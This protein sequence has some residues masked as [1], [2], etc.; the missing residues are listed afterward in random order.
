M[1]ASRILSWVLTQSQALF[2]DSWGDSGF[3]QVSLCTLCSINLKS[4]EQ[5]ANK[6]SL[7][8]IMESLQI[9]KPNNHVC[10]ITCIFYGMQRARDICTTCIY[11]CIYDTGIV[12]SESLPPPPPHPTHTHTR[13]IRLVCCITKFQRIKVLQNYRQ[14][15]SSAVY[16]ILKSLTDFF[17]RDW[18]DQ[19]IKQSYCFAYENRRS[20]YSFQRD[21]INHR[22]RIDWSTL[23]CPVVELWN[24]LWGLGTE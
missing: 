2:A 5:R 19:K 9:N 18:A 17:V 23:P 21:R 15:S 7:L 4:T 11:L 24:N 13:H 10:S 1:H 8:F 6:T 22:N 20:I 3:F 12:H 14:A 16:N